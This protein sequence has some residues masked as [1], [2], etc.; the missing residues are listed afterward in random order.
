MKNIDFKSNEKQFTVTKYKIHFDIKQKTNN[1]INQNISFDTNRALDVSKYGL[2][3]SISYSFACSF[4]NNN[5]SFSFIDSSEFRTFFSDIY[6]FRIIQ[7]CEETSNILSIMRCLSLIGPF[8]EYFMSNFNE[9]KI[10]S[11]FGSSS[12]I[13][14]IR[15][16]FLN[17]FNNEKTPYPSDKFII[18]II[19]NLE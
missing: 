3:S 13:N 17:L 12:L 9:I 6:N 7:K 15:E 16:F 5:S 2:S 14:L 18:K 11:N 19:K 1:Y 8:V 4:F 10:F